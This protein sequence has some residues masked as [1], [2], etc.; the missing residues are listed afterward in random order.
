MSYHNEV[1]SPNWPAFSR[2]WKIV[3]IVLFLLLLL[4]WFLQASPWSKNGGVCAEKP[5][6][7]IIE[8]VAADTLAPILR[9]NDNSIVHVPFGAS[10]NDAG[11]M[12]MDN[13]DGETS[14]VVTGEVDYNT[15][16]E[17]VLT[18]TAIDKAGNKSSTTRTVIVDAKE[19]VVIEP[20]VD[21][22]AAARLY[23]G[24]GSAALPTDSS[25]TIADVIAYLKRNTD[26]SAVI[27]GF[28]SA[29]GNYEFNQ[30]L[31]KRRAESVSELLQKAGLS[32]DRIILEKPVETTG[33]GSEAEARRVEVSVR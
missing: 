28:H 26:S 13:I 22:P 7:R 10:Y 27:S 17:Y 14:V 23:F 29:V 11:A 20:A 33:S 16:G 9:L 31:S 3:A 25:S 2:L 19:S 6:E 8:T 30:A 18:Y 1:I 5:V 15:Q 12:A 21:L 32:V 4:L 24:N